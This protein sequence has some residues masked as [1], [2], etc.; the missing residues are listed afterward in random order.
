M[1]VLLYNTVGRWG[2]WEKRLANISQLKCLKA[3][4]K[5][6][7]AQSRIPSLK[8]PKFRFLGE[9]RISTIL[10]VLFFKISRSFR[11]R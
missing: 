1:I 3:S 8:N 9:S 4:K 6:A 10:L 5:L 7:E 11:T 2:V